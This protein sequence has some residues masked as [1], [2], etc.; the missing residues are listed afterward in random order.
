MV[1]TGALSRGYPLGRLAAAVFLTALTVLTGL[2]VLTMDKIER[3]DLMNG[4]R[5]SSQHSPKPKAPAGVGLGLNFALFTFA[6]W[7]RSESSL[8]AKNRSVE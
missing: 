6:S 7:K 1:I 2:T 5:Q 4:D 3:V 8:A